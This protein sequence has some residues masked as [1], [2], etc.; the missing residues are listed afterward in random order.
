MDVIMEAAERLGRA[1]KESELYQRF[2]RAKSAYENDKTLIGYLGEYQA[3]KKTL[4][5][6]A[7]MEDVDT[8]LVDALN[9]RIDELYKLIT[10][11]S[12]Y[13]EYVTSQNAVNKL[14]EQVNIKITHTI[15]GRMP[16]CGHDCADCYSG[17]HQ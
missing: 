4:E 2:E 7:Q 13:I 9:E 16:A 10:E 12:V 11:N 14:M 1:I 6:A 8:H 15:T 17:C 3:D 5:R